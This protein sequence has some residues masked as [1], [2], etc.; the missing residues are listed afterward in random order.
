MASPVEVDML[1]D[2]Q[3]VVSYRVSRVF[4]NAASAAR[5]QFE[6]AQINPAGFEPVGAFPVGNNPAAESQN[7]TDVPGRD[8][9]A[10]ATTVV[11]P[12]T[13]V[14]DED[15]IPGC[16]TGVCGLD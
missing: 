12:T 10:E 16:P 11:E 6:L 4:P 8:V 15:V 9:V 7:G 13:L 14:V 2:A 3:G 5:A 1:R